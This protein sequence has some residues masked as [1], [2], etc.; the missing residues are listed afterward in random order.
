MAAAGLS[1]PSGFCVHK[2]VQTPCPRH[3]QCSADCGDYVWISHDED[4]RIEMMKQWAFAM[5]AMETALARQESGRP[6]K[7]ADWI[8]HNRKKLATLSE[9]LKQNNIAPFDPHA[10]LQALSDNEK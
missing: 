2:F 7:S 1:A 5:V 9:Q 4:R 3:L 8:E 10:F 6:Q